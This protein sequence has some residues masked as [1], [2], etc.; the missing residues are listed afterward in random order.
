MSLL[1]EILNRRPRKRPQSLLPQ[2]L[3]SRP[4]IQEM[5]LLPYVATGEYVRLGDG[6][7]SQ[8]IE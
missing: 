4:N 8:S 7:A 1:A 5:A 2:E 6:T 3:Y